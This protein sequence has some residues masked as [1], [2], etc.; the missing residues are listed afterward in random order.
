MKVINPSAIY[1]LWLREMKRFFRAKSRV[2]GS[3]GMPLFF[4]LFMGTGFSRARL[5][6]IPAGVDYVDYLVPGIIGMIL[7]FGSMFAGISVIWDRQFGFLKE[8]MVTPVSRTSIVLGRTAGGVTMALF[9]GILILIAG[10]AMGLNTGFFNVLFSLIF[11]IL[12]SAGFVGLGLA[13]ASKMED[14]HGFQLIMNFLI[15]PIFF[16]SGAL[17]PITELPSVLILLSYLNPLTYGVDALRR[18]LIGTSQ[19]PLSIDILALLGFCIS[20]I[21]LGTYLFEKV[22]V[23]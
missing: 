15:F 23:D 18:I 20:M 9:Q 7:L 6:G 19:F 8:V 11:M 12:I 14:M 10:M 5:P 17:F 16:L 22:E 2:V 3:L 13:F 1:T 4:L 21:A